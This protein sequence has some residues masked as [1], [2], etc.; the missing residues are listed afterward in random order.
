M[1]GDEVHGQGAGRHAGLVGVV[2]IEVGQVVGVLLALGQFI[3]QMHLAPGIVGVESVLLQRRVLGLGQEE[4]GVGMRLTEVAEG[5]LPE[6]G[7]HFGGHVAAETVHAAVD[8]EFHL[9]FH[10]VIEGGVVLVVE[11]GDVSPVVLRGEV[12]E[13]IEEI[14]VPVFHRPGV[15]AAGV[16][17]YPVE[18]HFEALFVG[19][20]Q[21]VVEVFE[22]AEFGVHGAIVLHGIVAAEGALA[23]FHADGMDGHQP[24]DVDAQSGEAVELLF[25]GGERTF[26]RELADV[27][28][29][30]DGLLRPVGVF[31]VREVDFRC[32]R[33]AGGQAA[34]QKQESQDLF[35][36]AIT[37]LM[38]AK[39]TGATS[40]DTVDSPSQVRPQGRVSSTFRG[41]APLLS[42]VTTVSPI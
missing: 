42:T 29:I 27:D 17:G 38:I 8:P 13:G 21:E 15:V 2:H 9:G 14:P 10:R 19:G 31:D 1:V 33:L 20:G 7:R 41:W 35:H 6:I 34:E 24:E 28:L 22:R 4:Q 37:Y 39:E 23:A 40:T 11:M 16:V 5:L 30:D 36:S 3:P 32:R 25:N 12:A 18:D 26:L